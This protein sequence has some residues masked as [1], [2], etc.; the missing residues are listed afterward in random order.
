MI[1]ALPLSA[2]LVAFPVFAEPDASLYFGGRTGF[3]AI[4]ADWERQPVSS[5]LGISLYQDIM[6]G[7]KF[8]EHFAVEFGYYLTSPSDASGYDD[9]WTDNYMQGAFGTFKLMRDVGGADIYGGFSMMH[10]NLNMTLNGSK[11]P[12]EMYL[13]GD[14]YQGNFSGYAGKFAA[15]FNYSPLKN[16]TISGE[17]SYLTTTVKDENLHNVG[18]GNLG[19]FD[20]RIQATTMVIGIQYVFP[21]EDG[22]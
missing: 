1:R 2:A 10:I 6:A 22:R 17:L 21:L 7:V 8:H 9:D 5:S 11:L 19:A 18:L 12:G 4:K 13:F 14:D 15:G 3:M 16:L 20:V